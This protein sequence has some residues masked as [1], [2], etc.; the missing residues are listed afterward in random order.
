M[1]AKK[2][3]VNTII[4]ALARAVGILLALATIAI[5]TRHLTRNEWGE[6]SIMLTFGGIF[7]VIA[8]LGLY[9]L[10]VREISRPQA[11]ELKIASNIFTIRLLSGLFIFALAPLISLFFPYSEQAKLGILVGMAGFWLLSGGQVLIGLFQKY[12]QMIKV[13]TAELFGRLVQLGLVWW[14]VLSGAGFLPLVA[15]LSLGGLA[16]FLLIFWWARHYCRLRLAFDRAYWWNVLQQG[17]PLAVASILTMIYFSSDSLFLS[18]LKPAADV[19]IYRLPYKILEGLIF[20]PAMFVGLV[21]PLLSRFAQTDREK[22]KNIFQRAS[23]VL[24]VF[25]IPLVAGTLVLSPAI[26]NL[27]GGG[28]YNESTAIFNILIVAV[29][30]IFLGTLFSYVLIA[31]EKQK[32]LL[33]IS[34]V[35]AIF[36]IAANL[37]FI[38]RYSYYAAAAI[39][40]LTEALVVILMALVLYWFFR[41]L[42]SFKIFLKSLLAAAGM[43]AALWLLPGWN[44]ALSLVVAAIVYFGLLYLLRGFSRADIVNLIGGQEGENMPG[45]EN[46]AV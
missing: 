11:D 38:P 21:M 39:T 19:G 8:D 22:F 27:L 36:N 6:Y 34:G 12:L 25:A 18:I 26:I 16:N 41:W 1:L 23:D 29:G 30:M 42:P 43:M 46:S 40:V 9:Q 3:A 44:L 17:Y 35:A 31:L 2:I 14:L 33:W 5:I 4:S 45:S 24:I 20:F 37:I 10:M 32:S 28:K 13:A 7:A 15:A